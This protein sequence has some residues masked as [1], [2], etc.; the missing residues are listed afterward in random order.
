MS[1]G[2]DLDVLLRPRAVPLLEAG[3]PS[4]D[5]Y[6]TLES[7]RAP[8]VA[9]HSYRPPS[10][11]SEAQLLEVL[12]ANDFRLA[13]TAKALNLSRTSLYALVEQSSHIRKAADIGAQEIS[14]AVANAAGKLTVAAAA[15]EVS[16]HALKLRMR[17][18]GLA[19]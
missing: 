7:P 18:L 3:A 11:V 5:I 12:R 9:R 4:S 13:P 6:E 15:L 19:D 1:L 10:E 14:A 2:S 17:A 16:A 8:A